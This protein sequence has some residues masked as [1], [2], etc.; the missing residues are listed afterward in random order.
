MVRFDFTQGRRRRAGI[1]TDQKCPIPLSYYELGRKSFVKRL[2]LILSAT[3][4]VHNQ[5]LFFLA[6]YFPLYAYLCCPTALNLSLP[7]NRVV[8]HY[9]IFCLE[10]LLLLA[11]VVRVVSL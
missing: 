1:T 10:L 7:G 6:H 5:S 2:L 9:H 3:T 4:L 11:F 8:E